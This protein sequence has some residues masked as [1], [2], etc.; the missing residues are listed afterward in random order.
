M[1]TRLNGKTCRR[2]EERHR[3]WK[4][5]HETEM[6]IIKHGAMGE[7]ELNPTANEETLQQNESEDIH[8]AGR[9]RRTQK[10]P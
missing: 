4:S 10:C 7:L 6:S 5:T 8:K 3:E 1:T 2:L 9:Q